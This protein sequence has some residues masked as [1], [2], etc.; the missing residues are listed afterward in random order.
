MFNLKISPVDLSKYSAGS[1]RPGSITKRVIWYVVSVV[2]FETPIPFPSPIKVAIL[3]LFGAKVDKGVV[4]K[5]SVKIKYPWFLVVGRY[6]WLG[7]RVWIDNLAKVSIGDNCCVSQEAYL[8]TGNHDYSDVAFALRIAPIV[9]EPGAWIG[10]KSLVCP[11]LTVGSGAVLCAGSV[12]GSDL[13]P[14][15]VYQGNPAKLVRERKVR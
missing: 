2:F 8:L 4:I 12:A 6:V 15:K 11:G 1:Y 9:I 14:M 7:E 3:R 10:A 13:L 5:P